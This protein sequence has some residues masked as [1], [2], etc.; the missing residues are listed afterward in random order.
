[1]QRADFATLC[2]KFTSRGQVGLSCADLKATDR[3]NG[4]QR[5]TTKPERRHLVQVRITVNLA[6]GVA[7][8]GQLQILRMH[9]FA[10]VGHADE[11]QSTC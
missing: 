11:L 2:V 10:V 6:G 8:H 7:D 1:M 4:R 9:T 5:F 3:R